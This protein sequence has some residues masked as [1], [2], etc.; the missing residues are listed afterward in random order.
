MENK[1]MTI[2]KKMNEI[3][4]EKDNDES[5]R[6]ENIILKGGE[7]IS[8]KEN[9]KQEKKLVNVHI[10]KNLLSEIDLILRRQ[11]SFKSRNV[12]ILEAIQEKL[13]KAANS[14]SNFN[15]LG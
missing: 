1:N 5:K 4:S 11:G 10:P 8:D 9:I 3:F 12:W 2:K 7:V 15:K 6:I 13:Y 14:Q